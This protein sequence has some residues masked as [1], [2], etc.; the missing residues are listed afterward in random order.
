MKSGGHDANFDKSL[1]I[2]KVGERIVKRILTSAGVEFDDVS[3][4]PG[5]RELGVDLVL[6]PTLQTPVF[7]DVKTHCS[8]D[9]FGVETMSDVENKKLGCDFKKYAEYFYRVFP[10]TFQIL[11]IRQ[12]QFIRYLESS[13]YWQ[14]QKP[15]LKSNCRTVDGVEKKWSSEFRDWEI[16]KLPMTGY[17]E[18]WMKVDF[19]PTQDEMDALLK[20]EYFRN[21]LM[22]YQKT[23]PVSFKE[24][25]IIRCPFC[26][27]KGRPGNMVAKVQRGD[28]SLFFACENCFAEH[29]KDGRIPSSFNL[30]GCNKYGKYMPKYPLEYLRK[31]T[32]VKAI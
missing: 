12:Q 7:V 29:K 8:W 2:G 20:S 17:N 15:Y 14:N 23:S 19:M 10:L 27:E 13:V 25:D 11:C 24:G 6:R 28:G 21:S 1:E 3:D 4:D 30:D 18:W 31:L 22:A 32:T 26:L 9:K 16:C 5:Y